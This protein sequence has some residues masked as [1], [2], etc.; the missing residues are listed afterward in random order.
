MESLS[1]ALVSLQVPLKAMAFIE[2]SSSDFRRDVV[3]GWSLSTT[4][5]RPRTVGRIALAH[6]KM[7]PYK[8]V[9][10]TA[11][12]KNRKSGHNY[13]IFCKIQ[14]NILEAIF[15]LVY[16]LSFLPPLMGKQNLKLHGLNGC[17]YR[18][19]LYFFVFKLK[20]IVRAYYLCFLF[21]FD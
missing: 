9:F 7:S 15:K 14:K 6:A 2:T 1:R 21:F 18:C 17:M 11:R 3:C 12:K 16:F 13:L 19:N 5:S 10:Q 8:V 4:T 20:L